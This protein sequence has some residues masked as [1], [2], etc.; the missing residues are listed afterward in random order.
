MIR[1]D[2]PHGSSAAAI[3]I[4]SLASHGLAPGPGRRHESAV[5]V[6]KSE[7]TVRPLTVTAEYSTSIRVITQ[8]LVTQADS[9][10]S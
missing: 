6:V 5:T 2:G 4:R 8:R 3:I 9:V 10:L 7:L 1:R